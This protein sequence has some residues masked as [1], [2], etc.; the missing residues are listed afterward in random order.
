[1][2]N[3]MRQA[4]KGVEIRIRASTYENL[5]KIAEKE[6]LTIEEAVMLVTHQFTNTKMKELRTSH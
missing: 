2:E 3:N 1:M 4:S 5:K 6:G